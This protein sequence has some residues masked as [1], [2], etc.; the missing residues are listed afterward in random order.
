MCR[1]R[2]CCC[3]FEL[4]TGAIVTAVLNFIGGWGISL[5][6][7]YSL[8][9]GE[10]PLFQPLDVIVGMGMDILALVLLIGII[11]EKLTLILVWVA[12]ELFLLLVSILDLE[13]V[14]F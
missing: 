7:I 10:P 1:L 11:K 9:Q 3:C 8:A 14:Y 4:R 13:M 5:P 2:S 6:A 12:A